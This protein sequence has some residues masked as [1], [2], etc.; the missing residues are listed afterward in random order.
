MQFVSDGALRC[1]QN[2]IDR[3]LRRGSCGESLANPATV[4][5]F[6]TQLRSLVCHLETASFADRLAVSSSSSGLQQVGAGS[7][8]GGGASADLHRSANLRRARTV[9]A[10]FLPTLTDPGRS[11]ASVTA[12]AT[13][14]S[15]TQ[16]SAPIT[17]S[18]ESKVT[19]ILSVLH[20][21]STG[22]PSVSERLLN[23]DSII[24]VFVVALFA[25]DEACVSLPLP[26]T[27]S[28]A[29]RYY[30]GYFIVHTRSL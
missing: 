11:S 15:A 8:R 19:A 27:A 2:L 18:L 13:A 24:H 7:D 25:K 9:S 20:S 23:C 16:I 4:D 12:I 21:L 22:S 30:C 3:H 29:I 14:A 17:G 28:L 26:S 10:L 1:Y 6:S 5:F